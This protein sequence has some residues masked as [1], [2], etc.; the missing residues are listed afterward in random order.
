MATLF[1]REYTRDDVLRH[2]GDVAQIARAKPYRL[3]DGFEEGTLAV[4]VETGSGFAFTVVASRC[5]DVSSAHLRGRSLA[6]RTAATDRHPAFYEPAGLGWLRSF[7]GGLVTTCG[8]TWMGGP[9][10]DGDAE[11]GLHG[12][13]SNT[14]ANNVAWDGHWDGDEYILSVSGKVRESVLFGENV[15]LTRRVWA[16]MGESSLHID[17]TVENLGFRPVPHMILYHCNFGFPL[18]AEGGR[19]VLPTDRVEPRDPES[20]DGREGWAVIDSP[21]A[22]YREKVYF[23]DMRADSSGTA[24]A[25]IVNPAC[26]GGFGAYV[27]YRPAELPWFTHWKMMGA[28]T[29]VTG[30]EPGNARVLGRPA[31][32]EAGRLQTLAPGERREYHLEIG[33]VDGPAEL[34][35]L[36]ARARG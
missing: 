2:V 11:L 35:A 15:E 4:D 12:R 25:A 10:V 21:V 20:A 30:L 31:E 27:R 17:D 9:T 5:L 7:A 34:A 13:A 22:G 8:L 36:E 23:H 29:Y 1:G 16:R 19:I 32:R 24:T 3:V 6:L 26:D 18:V 33:A 14:P 28:G